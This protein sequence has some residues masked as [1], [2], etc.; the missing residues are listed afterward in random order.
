MLCNL[1]LLASGLL[2]QERNSGKEGQE[3]GTKLFFAHIAYESYRADPT[4]ANLR[5][6]EI[7]PAGNKEHAADVSQ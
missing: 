7:P 5:I 2:S 6:D 4:R 1:V 3:Q